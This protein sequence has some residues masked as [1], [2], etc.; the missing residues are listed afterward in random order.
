MSKSNNNSRDGSPGTEIILNYK[1]SCSDM[2]R[3]LFRNEK[4]PVVHFSPSLSATCAYGPACEARYSS[5]NQWTVCINIRSQ[6][7]GPYRQLK[8]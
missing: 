1:R 3:R 6:Q 7:L 2:S 8:E 5:A 4:D